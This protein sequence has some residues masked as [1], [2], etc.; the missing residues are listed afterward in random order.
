MT[1]VDFD[2]WSRTQLDSVESATLV[3]LTVVLKTTL[4]SVP[5]PPPFQYGTQT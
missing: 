5:A 1:Q 3:P 2:T 4:L